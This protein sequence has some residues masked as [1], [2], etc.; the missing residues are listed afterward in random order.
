MKRLT[1]FLSVSFV[2][3]LFARILFEYYVDKVPTFSV[4]LTPLTWLCVVS[5]ILAV[6]FGALIV[7]KAFRRN[8]DD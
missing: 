4:L 6:V 8:R 2:L 3:L 1:I 7:I 5:G